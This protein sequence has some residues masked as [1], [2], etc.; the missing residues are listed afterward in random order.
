M[1]GEFSPRRHGGTEKAFVLVAQRQ[2][3]G[4]TG[5]TTHCQIGVSLRLAWR[6]EQFPID[7]EL[8]AFRK[9][10]TKRSHAV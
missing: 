6:G 8:H 3:T 1:M 5:K 4:S 9:A 2:Y 7:F 10:D